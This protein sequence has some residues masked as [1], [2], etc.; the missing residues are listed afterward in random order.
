[1]NEWDATDY[2]AKDNLLRVVRLE[3]G[4]L[5]DMAEDGDRWTASTG[6]P[7]WEVR[8][9]VGH[10]IDV[11][12]SYFTGFDAAAAGGQVDDPLGMRVMQE[13]LDEGAKSHR[14]LSQADAVERLR[15]DFEKMMGL[16]AA[17]GP[18]EWG[19]H[20]VTHKYMGPLPAF[21]YPV[22]TAGTSVR[23]PAGRTGS[24]ATPRTCWCRSCSSCGRRRRSLWPTA[25]RSP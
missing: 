18:G 9:I 2:A 25:R 3:A 14:E 5:F 12:E 11:T 24:A 16:A 4:A 19:G 1:M 22:C 10:L 20:L 15:D 8:D 7:Q 13:R 17:L 21:F 6:C 23:A